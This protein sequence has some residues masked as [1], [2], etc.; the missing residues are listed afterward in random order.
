MSDLPGSAGGL[1]TLADT[2]STDTWPCAAACAALFCVA[3]GMSSIAGLLILRSGLPTPGLL[4]LY[5][6]A[7][8]IAI[9]FAPFLLPQR[10]LA[11]QQGLPVIASTTAL[12]AMCL[13]LLGFLHPT[14]ALFGTGAAALAGLARSLRWLVRMSAAGWLLVLA[15]AP[16][17]ALHIFPLDGLAYVYAA[18][19]A[20]L[21]LLDNA[22][23]FQAAVTHMIQL[24]GVPSIGADGLQLLHYHFGSHFW[25]AG[26]G[27]ATGAPPLYVYPFAQT[28][29]LLPVLY[30]GVA[31]AAAVLAR[32][33]VGAVTLVAICI[34][35]LASFDAFISR[36]HNSSESYTFSLAAFLLILPLVIYLHEAPAASGA[37]ARRTAGLWLVALLATA[38]ITAL[39]VS[40]GYLLTGMLAYAA[41]RRFG[42]GGPTWVVAAVLAGIMLCAKLVF[43]PRGFVIGDPMILLASYKQYIVADTFFSLLLPLVFLLALR[44]QPR[45]VPAAG[46]EAGEEKFE[47][48]LSR[49]SLRTRLSGI[50]RAPRRREELWLVGLLVAFLPVLVL[51]IGSNAVY[52]S[53]MPHWLLLP[54][55]VAWLAGWAGAQMRGRCVFAALAALVLTTLTFL[56]VNLDMRGVRAFLSAVDNGAP[57]PKLMNEPQAMKRFFAA[58]LAGER[59]FFGSQFVAKLKENPW[60]RF[61]AD[62]HAM[63]R[64][65]G[66]AFAVFVPPSNHAFWNKLEGTGPYW[67]ADM[68]LYI[69]AQAGA[70]MLKGLQPLEPVCPMF[71]PGS[72][73]Y[74][75][76]AHTA[77][78]DDA[79]LCKHAA[80]VGIRTVLIANSATEPGRN[81]TISCNSSK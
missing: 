54:A 37:P 66:A 78:L 67:C 61:G 38:A 65:R 57:G 53:A 69:P 58:N 36:V 21:G 35:L 15:A 10:Y 23:Y 51:P 42:V 44:Y 16:L 39:K 1:P 3:M 40:T 17:A 56:P 6:G 32:P 80:T 75:A 20:P 59:V 28:A 49:T 19:T 55:A 18:E 2:G 72:P 64:E 71:A 24:H 70:V 81:R 29:V 14:L 27:L 25:F 77:E 5:C 68:H 63:A 52:F 13:P 12:A 73:D 50:L 43:S 9:A 60:Q 33:G 45:L 31:L 30:L 8:L 76:A 62:L 47:L 79:G 26:I 48:T 7:L 4:P 22:T 41:W 11:G 46:A 34:G 74:G